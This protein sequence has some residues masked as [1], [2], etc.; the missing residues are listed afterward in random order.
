[1][2]EDDKKFVETTK[3]A[4]KTYMEGVKIYMYLYIIEGFDMPAKDL[5]GTSDPYL[6]V[7]MGPDVINVINFL[8]NV[9]KKEIYSR[10]Q[11]SAVQ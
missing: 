8:S 10:D 11:Q 9:V 6:V 3:N 5:N 1:M 4:L 7:K 2:S